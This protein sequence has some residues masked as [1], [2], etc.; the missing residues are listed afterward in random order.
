MTDQRPIDLRS[1]TVTLPSPAMMQA[2]ATAE[3][4]DDVY[5]GDPT[6]RRL[7]RAMADT[8]GMQAGLLVTSGTQSNLT[9]LMA[10]LQRGE[11]FIVGDQFHIFKYEGGG[12]AVLGALVP[13]PLPTPVDGRL[14]PAAVTAA[15][16]PDDVHHPIT[17]LLCLENTF[18]GVPVPL[19][20]QDNLV[21][22]A[23]HRGLKVHLD[24]ARLFNASTALGVSP[25]RLCEGLDSVSVCLSK[26]L[27]APVGSVLCGSRDFI[28]R[29]R[30]VR[31][32]LG[33]GLRQAGILAACGLVALEEE[34][35]RLAED[36]ANARRLADGLRD[37]EGID[38][39]AHS[40]S[41]NMVFITVDDAVHA[42]LRQHLHASG[43]ITG[44]QKP[45]MRLV[46]HRDISSAD[47][48]RVIDAIRLFYADY[49]RSSAASRS[50]A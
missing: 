43:I 46:T 7:E 21:D 11:E 34:V 9:A 44:N 22:I 47:I 5:G 15:I 33:G 6:V 41:T 49:S 14:D 45:V 31:K 12:A 48:D 2:I 36:H 13:H 8:V 16:R 17:R 27:G 37:I 4:G 38:V 39:H 40:G 26:G 10:H 42:A 1:D 3:L 18:N 24:G 50:L 29:A 20:H 19:A 32:L 23:R 30:R 35:P 25:Q 28:E